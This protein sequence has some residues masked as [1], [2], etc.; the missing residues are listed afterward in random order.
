MSSVKIQCCS[1]RTI[2]IYILVEFIC[3]VL[4]NIICPFDPYLQCHCISFFELRIMFI[5]IIFEDGY[6]P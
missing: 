5:F 1:T 6:R 2:S 3:S 4:S